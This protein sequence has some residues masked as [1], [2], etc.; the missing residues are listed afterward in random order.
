MRLSL[1]AVLVALS[2]SGCDTVSDTVDEAACAAS[3]YADSGEV[4]ATVG[5]SR[6][7]TACVRVDEV[8]GQITIASI[9]NVVSDS[10][11]R[12]LAITMPTT[13]GTF[14]IG[15]AATAAYTQRAAD[16][17]QQAAQTYAATSGTVTVTAI[18]ESTATGTFA[19]TAQNPAGE[20]LDIASG[21]FDVSF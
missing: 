15:A 11:Q 12:L 10:N 19:F 17:G 3:G 13:T 4:S 8:S 1:F 6:Y 5:P 21:R 9:D 2:A 20:D 7:A 16:A 18:S 14:A